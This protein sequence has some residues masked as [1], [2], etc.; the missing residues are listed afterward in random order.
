MTCIV[1]Y[2]DP[3]SGV[4]YMGAD[5]FSGNP[6]SRNIVRNAKLV[7]LSVK[8]DKRQSPAPL[9]IGYTSSWRM[10]QLLSG[11]LQP[12]E[13]KKGVDVFT[14]LSVD[15]AEAVRKLFKEA[16]YAKVKDNEEEGGTFLVAMDGRL[17]TV[18]GNYSVIESDDGYDSCGAGEDFALGALHVLTSV[19]G[20]TPPLIVRTALTAAEHHSPLVSAPIHVDTVAPYGAQAVA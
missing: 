13:W 6:F 4:V 1:G 2:V 17:F 9:L 15:F 19:P 12:P 5:S 20:M 16:G 14:Y 3:E 10:G 7:R 11:Q 18:Q 8:R